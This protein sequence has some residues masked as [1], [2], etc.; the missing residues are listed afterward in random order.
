MK[1][2][3]KLM[4]VLLIVVASFAVTYYLV[5]YAERARDT[6]SLVTVLGTFAF[7]F[8]L[9]TV[10]ADLVSGTYDKVKATREARALRERARV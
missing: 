6:I 7:F 4:L 3:A 5:R 10:Y 9:L 8:F 2:A 1:K